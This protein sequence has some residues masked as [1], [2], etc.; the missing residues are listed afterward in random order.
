VPGGLRLSVLNAA[1]I[2][3]AGGLDRDFLR[4]HTNAVE[5]T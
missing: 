2:L 4:R 1:E 3:I 5:I